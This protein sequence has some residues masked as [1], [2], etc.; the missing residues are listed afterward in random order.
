MAGFVK[1][2]IEWPSPPLR[3]SLPPGTVDVWAWDY[4]RSADDLQAQIALLSPDEQI[5]MNRF[6][7]PVDRTRFAVSHA[8]LR[9][10]L[11][12]YAGVAPSSLLFETNEY[13]KPHLA[14]AG[15]LPALRF[16][17]SHTSSIALLAV[18]S[19]LSVGVDVEEIRP[20]EDEVAERYFSTR[21]RAELKHL[22]GED[23]LEGFYHAWT[24]KEA[25]LK[26]ESIGLSGKLDAFDVSLTPGERAAVLEAR[27]AAGFT[28]PWHLV[29]LRPANGFIGALAASAV[30]VAIRCYGFTG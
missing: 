16:N 30:P 21:E 8:A 23:W 7:Y 3:I 4:V 10:L 11:A 20:M 2:T 14:T 13:G 25:I 9:R 24:R 6:V 5:R 28:A 1:T 29:E 19:D 17:M 12:R 26:A 15:A 18:A 27:P 22:T